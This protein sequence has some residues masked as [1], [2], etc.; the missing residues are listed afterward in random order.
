MSLSRRGRGGHLVPTQ[1]G[2][3]QTGAGRVLPHQEG[4]LKTWTRGQAS[5][6]MCMQGAACRRALLVTGLRSVKEARSLTE[7]E[8]GGGSRGGLRR[9][10]AGVV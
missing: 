6:L 3:L 10:V 2:W 7:N 9:E 8:D 5:G 4:K 1:K